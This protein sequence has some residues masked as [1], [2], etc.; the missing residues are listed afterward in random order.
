M[1]PQTPAIA[2]R[3]PNTRDLTKFT[4]ESKPM[5]PLLTRQ[6]VC[7][8][9]ILLG[10]SL[11]L[12]VAQAHNGEPAIIAPGTDATNEVD[13]AAGAA[14]DTLR[15]CM[16]R[17][18]KDASIGQLMIAE[19]GCW[20]DERDRNPIQSIPGA[21]STELM[22]PTEPSIG[23]HSITARWLRLNESRSVAV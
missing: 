3:G 11:G 4:E 7:I 13:L 17:I 5:T 14:Q 2:I 23:N 21:R 16:A 9:G 19:Q 22:G 1:G 18:P 10:G 15:A 12:A 20:R 6:R 8:L